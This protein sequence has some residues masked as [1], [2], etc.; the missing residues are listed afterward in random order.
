MKDCNIS[1][2]STSLLESLRLNLNIINPLNFLIS[3]L[4]TLSMYE[5]LSIFQIVRVLLTY[6]TASLKSQ[7]FTAL[8]H[9]LKEV[10]SCSSSFSTCIYCFALLFFSLYLVQVFFIINILSNSNKVLDSV[11]DVGSEN[12]KLKFYKVKSYISDSCRSSVIIRS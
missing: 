3:L 4:V 7:L 5:S 11:I 12:E 1:I 2:K 9:A 8:S 10:T 6:L